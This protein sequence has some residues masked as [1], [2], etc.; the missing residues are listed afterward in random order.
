[1][2]LLQEIFVWLFILIALSFLLGFLWKNILTGKKYRLILFPGTIVHE[3]SHI[4]GCLL[5][6]SKIKKV[7]FFSSR[8]SYVAHTKPKIPLIGN[9]IVSFAPIAGGIAVLFFTFRFFGY[10]FPSATL[11]L[12]SFSESFFALVKETAI[13]FL[14]KYGTWQ[15]WV[16]SYIILSVVVCLVPSKEDFKNSFSSATFVFFLLLLSVQFNFSNNPITIFLK[17][18]IV[19]ALEVGIF[20][21][22]LGILVAIP[23]YLVKKIIL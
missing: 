5:T 18:N 17:E 9:F 19:G 14:D 10:D 7:E 6:G 1:M 16:S 4:L 13:F 22:L 2:F 21:G 20:F 12:E 8:G 11:S 15:F 23:V 3:V